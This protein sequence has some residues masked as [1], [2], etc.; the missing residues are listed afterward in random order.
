MLLVKLLDEAHITANKNSIPFD[1]ENFL[2]TSGVRLGT[3]AVTTR[4]MNE[5]DMD[6][7]AEIIEIVLGEKNIEK[8]KQMSKALTNKYPLYKDA[9]L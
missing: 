9:V 6:T 1:P 4:G 8:A 5:E 2:I 7:I 3:P